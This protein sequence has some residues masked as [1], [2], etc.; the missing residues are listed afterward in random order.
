MTV[1]LR[2]A[3]EQPDSNVQKYPVRCEELSVLLPDKTHKEN[4]PCYY[5]TQT[6][7]TKERTLAKLVSKYTSVV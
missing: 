6:M 3:R 5:N 7:R 4:I 1:D 2:N